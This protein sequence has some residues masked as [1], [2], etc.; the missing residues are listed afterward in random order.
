[1]LFRMEEHDAASAAAIN[2]CGGSLTYGSLCA[3]AEELSAQVPKRSLVFSFC[4]NSFGALVGYVGFLS[5]QAVPLLL[6][7]DMDERMRLNLIETYRPA[8]LWQ[9]EGQQAF[10]YR[11]VYGVFGYELLETGLGPY[12]L[13][14]DLALLITT[15]GSTGSPKL[16]RQTLR[17]IESNAVSIASYLEIDAA[18][19]PITTL[20]MNYVY[21][22]SIVNSHLLRGATLLLTTNGLMQRQFWS[23]FREQRATS[24][25]GVPYTYEMLKKLRLFSMDLPSLR[26]M[27]QA[28]GK[29]LPELHREF[30]S[31]AAETGRKFIVMYGAAEATARMGYLP[32]GK[33]L[34]KCGSMGIA[35]PGGRF[36]IIGEGGREIC[37]P[38]VVGEL[39]YYGDNV[40]PGYAER[41]EDLAKGDERHGRLL[42]GDMVERDE[43]G[44]YYVV[45][46]KKRFLKI[47][48]NRVGLDETERLIKARYP[49]LECACCG[50]DDL[51]HIFIT[52]AGR[53]DEIREFVS[54]VTGINR[55]GFRVRE[56][57]EIPKN[58]SGK[59]LYGKLKEYDD[60]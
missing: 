41:G 45:G 7:R 49:G 58:E 17:N 24:I 59:T 56:I 28:G 47:F 33:S 22:A 37:D 11:R 2:E 1:M 13:H 42:T 16:V 18:E 19:R 40:T 38:R 46:R 31:F 8:Y 12:P 48:G 23:F 39:V 4:E 9:P 3:A 43:D 15:S 21:G 52:E 14:D 57:E 60:V 35:I 53:V 30:A 27:T 51:M 54:G 32:A 36:S 55:A 5:H 25:A 26:T 6:D 29:L 10:G 44:F 50:V 20:P 34:E